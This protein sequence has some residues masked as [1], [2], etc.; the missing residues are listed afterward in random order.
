M[1]ALNQA[2]TF[3]RIGRHETEL[4]QPYTS[5]LHEKFSALHNNE[6]PREK[7]VNYRLSLI[8]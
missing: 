6:T 2:S 8:S 3:N 7:V 4:N 1:P 5:Q